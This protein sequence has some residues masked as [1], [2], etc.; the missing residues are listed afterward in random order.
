MIQGQNSTVGLASATSANGVARDGA[1][2]PTNNIQPG[3]LIAQCIGTITTASVVATYKW[4][5]TSDG[6]NWDEVRL[7]S[8]TASVTIAG[9]GGSPLAHR[10]ALS[11]PDLS[12]YGPNASARVNAT[13]SGAT[14][15]GADLTAVTYRYVIHGVN[16]T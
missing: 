1:S 16:D 9:G 7:P 5:V 10:V 12:G 8:N 2:L 14:T 6:T 11:C 4:Q 13:L 15:A 3:S